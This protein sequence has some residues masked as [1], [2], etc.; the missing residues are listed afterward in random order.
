MDLGMDA[1]WMDGTEPDFLTAFDPESSE[2]WIKKN[3]TCAMG[4]ITRYLNTYSLMTTKGIYDGW[5][6]DVEGKRLF[7]LTRSTFSG[8]QRY[9]AVTWSGDIMGNWEDFHNQLA[10]GLNFTM[11]G[12]PYWTTDIGG[13][14]MEPPEWAKVLGELGKPLT[15]RKK[16]LD[17]G[18][19]ELYVRWF[20]YGTFCPIFRSHGTDTP[21]EVWRFGE[22]GE[23]TYDTLVKFDN[24]RYRLMPYIY[25]VAWMV[26]DDGYTMMRGLAMDFQKDKNVFNIDDQFM[27]GPSILVNPVT[28]P[29]KEMDSPEREVY[30]PRSEG[31]FDFWT[32]KKLEGGQTIDG[33]APLS[34]MPLYVKA[35]SIIPI[36]PF[37]QYAMEK[38]DP[39]ELRVYP[40]AD[41]SF[42]LYEDE[43]DNYN[44][45]KGVYS[46][47]E[48]SWD[49][50]ENTLKIGKRQG[51]F[52]GMK[53]ERKIN[54]VIVGHGLGVG[55]AP[56]QSPDK[57]VS[58]DGN[59]VTLEF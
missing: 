54:I 14:F 44:Y 40:G 29:L 45:E 39:I 18:Y 36:G 34:I 20:Q 5:R 22:P 48:F 19:R 56:E 43:G 53:E 1:F 9:A 37:V 10:A 42:T 52:P 11:A 13:F 17:P 41:C 27:F 59:P 16:Y 35:G 2:E 6:R 49:D 57:T 50:S 15:N 58:Y 33:P 31:W 7:I 26:T 3:E 47:I 32:G 51:E 12:I 28:Q 25:S 23:E 8:Q 21:R 38:S 4:S 46:T 55:V 30:L 24:L